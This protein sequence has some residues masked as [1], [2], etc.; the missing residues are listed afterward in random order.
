[1]SQYNEI[2]NERNELQN[3]I[4]L[5]KE[6]LKQLKKRKT[7]EQIAN[8]IWGQ[9]SLERDEMAIDD[10]MYWQDFVDWMNGIEK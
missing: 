5:L 9:H 2:E 7:P 6:E 10:E 4:F 3:T 8:V 1:M